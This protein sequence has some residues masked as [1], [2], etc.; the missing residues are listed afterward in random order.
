MGGMHIF[1]VN[2]LYLH[3]TAEEKVPWQGLSIEDAGGNRQTVTLSVLDS[4]KFWSERNR[5][6]LGV[7]S[8][9]L[10][11]CKRVRRSTRIHDIFPPR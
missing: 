4:V 10:L 2:M 6:G 11:S 8:K 3:G 7:E 5:C 1:A 9:E